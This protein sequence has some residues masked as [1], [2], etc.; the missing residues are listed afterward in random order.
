M[1]VIAAHQ[2]GT[3]NVVAS[4]GTALTDKQVRVLKNLTRSF[5]FALD[6]DAAGNAATLRG[7]DVARGSLDRENLRAPNLLGAMSK[8]KAEMKIISLPSGKDPDTL[9]RENPDLWQQLILEAVP[10]VDHLIN[11]IS[12]RYDLTRPEGKSGAIEQLLPMVAELEDEVQREYYL[13]KLATILD[14]SEKTLLDEAARIHSPK[15]TKQRK[16]EQKVRT[17]YGDPVE[18]YCL[19][20]LLQRPEL[21][22]KAEGLAIEHFERSEN[23]E[24]FAA[25]SETLDISDL[26]GAV[27]DDIREYAEVLAGRHLPPAEERDW[28]IALTTCIGRLEERR[29]RAQEEYLSTEVVAVIQDGTELDSMELAALQQAP[30]DINE[31]LVKKMRERTEHHI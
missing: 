18:E 26:M 13:T 25:W 1:D 29:L 12:S 6:P 4:M 2:H 17:R 14:V 30:I 27:S 19:S 21:R 15:K 8:L 5:T 3:T 31:R 20:M 22:E 16:P 7:I 10:L 24:I 23:R 11:V 28:E 9:I